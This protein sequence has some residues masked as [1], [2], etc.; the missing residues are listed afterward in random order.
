MTD[1]RLLNLAQDADTLQP[2]ALEALA[3]ELVKRELGM[4]DI[5]E[6]AAGRRS[7]EYITRQTKPVSRSFNGIGTTLYGKRC[8]GADGSFITTKWITICW[9]PLIPLTSLRVKDVGPG[10]STILGWSRRYLILSEL[11]TDVRQVI[12]IYCFLGSFLIGGRI[13]D[14]MSAGDWV[15]CCFF[16]GW[17]CTPWA[18]RKWA[19]S[20][21]AL[22]L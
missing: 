20:R 17:V 2:E 16:V 6:Y 12:N 13:L 8:F 18:L 21:F 11:Q 15:A 14:W 1:D 5:A 22:D 7:T 3:S 19:R 10:E 4:S 9:V